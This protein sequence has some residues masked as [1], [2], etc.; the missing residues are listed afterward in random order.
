MQ[1]MI[2]MYESMCQAQCYMSMRKRNVFIA[3]CPLP[4]QSGFT[5]E[6]FPALCT[7]E[8]LVNVVHPRMLQQA[9]FV[10]ARLAALRARV[11]R[12]VLGVILPHVLGDF[13][14]VAA[15]RPAQETTTARRSCFK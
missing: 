5:V 9:A 14:L 1:I 11:R 6:A 4:S 10:F 8:G 12:G 7:A 13:G 15:S 2:V 3:H